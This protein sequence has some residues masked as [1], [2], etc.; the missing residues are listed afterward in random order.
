[1]ENRHIMAE[2]PVSTLLSLWCGSLALPR[3]WATVFGM[4]PAME[5]YSIMVLWIF[6]V[7]I[8]TISGTFTLH[9]IARRIIYADINI[10]IVFC[11]AIDVIILLLVSIFWDSISSLAIIIAMA[12]FSV[13]SCAV[14]IILFLIFSP[15]KNKY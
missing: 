15:E 9:L 3:I 12:L 7:F 5:G 4:A 2:K 10:Y 14:F 6:L 11:V 1:M 8:S 13:T